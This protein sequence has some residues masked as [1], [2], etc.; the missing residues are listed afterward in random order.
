MRREPDGAEVRS[1]SHGR[2]W[3]ILCKNRIPRLFAYANACLR[4]Q[5]P[6]GSESSQQPRRH[7]VIPRPS[8]ELVEQAFGLTS[9]WL[10]EDVVIEDGVTEDGDFVAKE[11]TLCE[12]GPTSPIPS[13]SPG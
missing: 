12:T 5:P 13:H 10:G 11:A 9:A 4:R 7:V 6:I 2:P 1:R 3:A 8:R